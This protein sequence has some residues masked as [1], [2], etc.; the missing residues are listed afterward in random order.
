M[1]VPT[2]L[3]RLRLNITEPLRVK[4][5]SIAWRNRRSMADEITIALERHVENET[6]KASDLALE[7]LSDAS[8][9]E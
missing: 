2:E 1:T 9:A 5:N 4:L 3:V 6:K 8:H 7:K